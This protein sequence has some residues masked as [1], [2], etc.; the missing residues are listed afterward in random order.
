MSRA[1]T[2]LAMLGAAA[3]SSS[4]DLVMHLADNFRELQ[5]AS[6]GGQTRVIYKSEAAG[7]CAAI[8]FSGTSRK[9]DFPLEKGTDHHWTYADQESWDIYHDAES[10]VHSECGYSNTEYADS[11][12]GESPIDVIADDATPTN[13]SSV[14]IAGFSRPREGVL[15]ANDGHAIA[16]SVCAGSGWDCSATASFGTWPK[17]LRGVT[18]DASGHGD[19]DAADDHH[20]RLADDDGHAVS[21][22]KLSA[23]TY[24]L[25]K[26]ELHW[27][28]ANEQ[29][30]EHAVCGY[31]A[32]GEAHFI[33][34]NRN[35]NVTHDR[36]DA[37]S[38]TK[39]VARR[40]PR[41]ANYARACLVHSFGVTV[42]G[43]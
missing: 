38:G 34:V 13:A 10:H 40:P 25:K 41:S 30:S 37:A 39:C 22:A 18:S 23:D 43:A 17:T 21:S 3:A 29:G 6:P 20:R 36:H 27:G 31:S 8:T 15:L 35:P 32:A 11:Y 26:V 4:T 24:Y 42:G 16:L 33:F 19:D 7:N 12:P 2:C 28:S 14:A 1:L 5:P 9:T